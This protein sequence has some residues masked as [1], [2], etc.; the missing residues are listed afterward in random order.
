MSNSRA[1]LVVSNLKGKP[2]RSDAHRIVLRR[3]ETGAQDVTVV[4]LRPTGNSQPDSFANAATDCYE[5]AL[6]G[7]AHGT[8]K[9]F[10]LLG[11]WVCLAPSR[12]EHQ[13]D[14][15]LGLRMPP[16]ACALLKQQLIAQPSS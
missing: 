14:Q 9:V 8:S 11:F 13:P 7:R 15:R 1:E 3:A 12:R 6:L 2:A 4:A 10:N 5:I 16:P